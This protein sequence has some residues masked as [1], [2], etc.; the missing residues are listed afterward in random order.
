[1][2]GSVCFLGGEENFKELTIPKLGVGGGGGFVVC[3]YYYFFFKFNI[4]LPSHS[5]PMIGSTI[6]LFFIYLLYSNLILIK[7]LLVSTITNNFYTPSRH[8]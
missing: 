6:T 4:Y 3:A 1:M 5:H 2:F 8:S 7:I